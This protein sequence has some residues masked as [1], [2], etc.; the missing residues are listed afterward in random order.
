MSERAGSALMAFEATGVRTYQA[1]RARIPRPLPRAEIDQDRVV[2]RLETR[3][4]IPHADGLREVDDAAALDARAGA[5]GPGG[6]VG[7]QMVAVLADR[8]GVDRHDG[9]GKTVWFELDAKP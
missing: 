1:P 9:D 3:A 7:I 6:A 4:S 2:D 8:W 5:P